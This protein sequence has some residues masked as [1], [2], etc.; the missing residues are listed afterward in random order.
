[1]T[2]PV[3]IKRLRGFGGRGDGDQDKD[4]KRHT[5]FMTPRRVLELTSGEYGVALMDDL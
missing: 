4:R 3:I 1:M 2:T 5:R